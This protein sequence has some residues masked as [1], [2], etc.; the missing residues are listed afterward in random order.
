MSRPKKVSR[1]FE[2]L[3]TPVRDENLDRL[4][5]DLNRPIKKEFETYW[6]VDYH[7]SRNFPNDIAT[8]DLDIFHNRKVKITIEVLPH[9]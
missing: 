8:R 1:A 6:M 4:A 9:G 5:G 7:G 3:P 2:Y